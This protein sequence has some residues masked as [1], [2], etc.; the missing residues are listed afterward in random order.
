M[1]RIRAEFR[2][3]SEVGAS[4][5]RVREFFGELENFARLM[6]GIES[7]LEE[8]RTALWNVHVETPFLGAMRG[9]FRLTQIDDSRLRIEWE[10]AAGE[11][12]NL[13][14]YAIAFEERGP[15]QTL[16]RFALRVELRRRHAAQLH[17][18]AGLIGES[19]ISASMQKGV[20]EMLRTFLQRTRARL[21]N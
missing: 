20:T 17:L 19:R 15:S 7:I 2:E 16:V 13:L 14:R 3:D 1:F 4:V 11:K 18:M 6:P 10:P 9:H 5:E 8:G 21:E 12:R